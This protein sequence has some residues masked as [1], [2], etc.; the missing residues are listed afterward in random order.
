M[1]MRGRFAFPAAP[2]PTCLAGPPVERRLRSRALQEPEVER[3]EHQ[4][5]PDVCYQPLPDLIPE[6]QDVRADHHSYHREHVKRDGCL[7]SH[8][9]CLLGATE[10]S[11][12]AADTFIG[13]RRPELVRQAGLVD[14]AVEAK[15][16]IY[17]AG[18]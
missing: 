2:E 1:A 15:A 17:P 3:D 18:H 11:K 14:V 10:W 16:D 4:D 9:F 8:R 5:N 12:S 7:V 13:R 6:E